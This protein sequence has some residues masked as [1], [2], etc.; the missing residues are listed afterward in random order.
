MAGPPTGGA[1]PAWQCQHADAAAEQLAYALDVLEARGDLDPDSPEAEAFVQ[2][3]MKDVTMHEVGHTLG[4][5]HNFRA[6][7]AV[8]DRLVND[9]EYT[10]THAFTGSV[11]EYS[12]INLPRPGEPGGTP[13]QTTLGPY[14]FWAIEYAYKP[15]PP[16]M[17]AAEQEAV[18][19]FASNLRLER[20]S[21]S[22]ERNPTNDASSGLSVVAAG[23][24]PIVI[25]DA[26]CATTPIA[27]PDV[28]ITGAGMAPPPSPT[29]Q[30]PTTRLHAGT[31]SGESAIPSILVPPQSMPMSI[32]SPCRMACDPVARALRAGLA[33]YAALGEWQAGRPR[34]DD[35]H[36]GRSGG[37]GP[38]HAPANGLSSPT[39]TLMCDP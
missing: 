2:A 8:S 19:V 12:A 26:L 36:A 13:F 9:P 1:E 3:Y 18:R 38:F 16:G 24:V 6:S 34:A 23:T 37:F 17:T 35:P 25:A 27:H 20:R 31:P 4:L 11:M 33:G 28:A 10:R 7:H 39:R 30:S 5:R 14:D 22:V 15:F 29:P 32:A 21:P